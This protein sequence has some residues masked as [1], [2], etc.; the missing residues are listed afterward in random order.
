M[1][2]TQRRLTEDEQR[3]LDHMT[4][5]V[6]A[7]IAARRAWLDAKMHET[8]RLHV[9]DEIYDLESGERLGR[10]SSL[11]RYWRDRDEGVR[12]ITASCEYEY[13]TSTRLCFDNTSRQPARSFGTLRDAVEYAEARAARLRRFSSAQPSPSATLDA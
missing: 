11:Y 3:E 10:I 9:G 12:D 1:N 7:A 5:I 4:S 13:E 8:S 6:T 2:D